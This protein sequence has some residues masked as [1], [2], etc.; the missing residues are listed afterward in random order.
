MS[1]TILSSS[2]VINHV[3]NTD[4]WQTPVRAKVRLLRKQGLSYGKIS[5]AT[6]LARSTIQRIVKAKSSRRGRKGKE[7]RP[8][9]ISPRT[10]RRIIRWV[11]TN[12]TTR[13]ASYS[14]IKA[15]LHIDAST[16]TIR[17]ALRE[18]ATDAVS[19]AL[20]L[21][22]IRIKPRDDSNLRTNI[23]GG[24][25]GIGNASYGVMSLLLRLENVGEY[26]LRV[27]QMKRDVLTVLS[28]FIGVEE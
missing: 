28:Q 6:G 5:D 2:P 3:P 17:R 26:G 22:L 19:H 7:Y 20:D 12:W 27:V 21:L 10:L 11:I 15:A 4:Y 24:G 9:R 25:H 23:G 8:K 18:Q 14:H 13:R 16:T 1:P